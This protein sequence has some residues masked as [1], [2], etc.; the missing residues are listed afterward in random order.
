MHHNAFARVAKL[1]DQALT[2]SAEHF[3]SRY[4]AVDQDITASC[5]YAESQC[6]R[7]NVGFPF[8]ITKLAKCGSQIVHLHKCGSQ[9]VHLRKEIQRIHRGKK[10]H[11]HLV[12]SQ[13]RHTSPNQGP[14]QGVSHAC[15]SVSM[16]ICRRS[17]FVVL[18]ILLNKLNFYTTSL[19]LPLLRL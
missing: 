1:P 7:Q 6:T 19:L 13:V 8:S 11:F 18:I 16:K 4:N 14:T 5:R 15:T 10:T 2:L 17:I 12:P 9:I 3:E